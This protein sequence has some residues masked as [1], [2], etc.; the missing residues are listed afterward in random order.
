MLRENALCCEGHC[1]VSFPLSIETQSLTF[2]EDE[3]D[4]MT[5]NKGQ[6]MK[7]TVPCYCYTFYFFFLN[8]DSQLTADKS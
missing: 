5:N 2:M 4:S 7:E 8:E 6:A 1:A 3:Q